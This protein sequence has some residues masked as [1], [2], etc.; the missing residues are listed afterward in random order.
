MEKLNLEPDSESE[1]ENE[2]NFFTLIEDHEDIE[3]LSQYLESIT[4]QAKQEGKTV[5]VD[6]RVKK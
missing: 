5:R 4:P 3:E 2:I 1:S 6:V